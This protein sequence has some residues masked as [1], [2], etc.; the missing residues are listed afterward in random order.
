MKTSRN[1]VVFVSIAALVLLGSA[2]IMA[3]PTAIAVTNSSAEAVY[4][5]LVLGQPPA[6]PPSGCSNLGQQIQSILDPNLV[7]KS[8]VAN[9]KVAF[10]PQVSGITTK[11]YYK[12]DSQETIT[13]QPQTFSCAAGTCSPAVTFNFFFTSGP[14]DGNPNNGCG[15]SKEFPNAT[16]LAEASV[17]FGINGS[18]GS[19]CAN[20]D[21]ADIS[22]VNGLNAQLALQLSGDSWPFTSASNANFGHN[23]NRQGVYGWAATNCVNNAGYPNPSPSCAVPQNAPKAPASGDCVTP[24]GTKYAPIVDSTT[25]AKYCDERSDASTTYPQGQ[26]V[27]QR[28]GNVTGGQVAITFSGFLK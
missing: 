25:K 7:F 24:K 10:T 8:S 28:P 22:V 5:T 21:A 12:L 19:T 2:P 26:C 11:G 17:N 27:S 14:Y 18:V 20:A 13:Y 1:P 9:K 6:T 4:A 3:A 15:G 23:A 16:N